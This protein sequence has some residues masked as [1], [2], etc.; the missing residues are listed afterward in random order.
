MWFD[1]L[2]D[3]IQVSQYIAIVEVE[4]ATAAWKCLLTARSPDGC[5]DSVIFQISQSQINTSAMKQDEIAANTLNIN[6]S[7]MKQNKT[8]SKT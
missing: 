1:L 4:M 3:K 8:A 6:T 2:I 5:Q 7:A